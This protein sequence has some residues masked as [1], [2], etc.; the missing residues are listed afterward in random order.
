[1]PFLQGRLRPV[2]VPDAQRVAQLIADLD[3]KQFAVRQKAEDELEKLGELVDPALI[4]VLAGKPSLETKQ[5]VEKLREKMVTGQAPSGEVLQA[6][7]A[8]AVLE[9]MGTGEARQLLEKLCQGAPGAK[10]DAR[11][12]GGPGPAGETLRLSRKVCSDSWFPARFGTENFF[13]FSRN[14]RA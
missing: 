6:L 7:R 4:Q 1:M 8:L 5:R 12:E 10:T 9:E 2:P 13:L 11:C 3:S 14:S